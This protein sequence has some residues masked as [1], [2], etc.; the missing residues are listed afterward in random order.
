VARAVTKRLEEVAA[1][2]GGPSFQI[3]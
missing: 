2:V 3:D 1:T